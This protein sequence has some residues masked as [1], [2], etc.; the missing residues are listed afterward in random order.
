M[1]ALSPNV[2]ERL[3]SHLHYS[4]ASRPKRDQKR[5]L[6]KILIDMY[7]IMPEI[8]NSGLDGY[9]AIHMVNGARCPIQT[10]V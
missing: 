10:T 9:M 3:V 8:Q 1:H 5:Q 4:L 6:Q 2:E 7:I